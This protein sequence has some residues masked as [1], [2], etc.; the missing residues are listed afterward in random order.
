MKRIWVK[1]SWLTS[2]PLGMASFAHG[3]VTAMTGNAAYVTPDVLLSILTAAAIRVEK[4]YADRKNG[5]TGK[6]ELINSVADLDKLLH[7]QA[8]YVTR[9]SGGDA[10][11]IHSGGWQTTNDAKAKASVAAQGGSCSLLPMS[12][13]SVKATSAAVKKAKVYVFVLVVGT[14][15]PITILNGL[16][17]IPV[18]V[19]AFVLNSTKR[20]ATFS[21]LPAKE[22][23]MVAVYTVNSAGTSVLSAVTSC[24]TLS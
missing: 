8:E 4:A 15:F 6:D 9:I 18:G 3:T 20:S 13:G 7:K 19:A 11:I 12:G 10:T 23:V 24:S 17:S 21:G 16:L 1:I 5:Q 2:N 14:V 22:D